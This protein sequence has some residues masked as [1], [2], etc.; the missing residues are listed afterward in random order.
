MNPRK[1]NKNHKRISKKKLKDTQILAICITVISLIIMIS[2]LIH[3]YNVKNYVY[4]KSDKGK[5]LVYTQYLKEDKNYTKEVPYINMNGQQIIEVNNQ[6]KAFSTKYTEL[7][8]AMLTY[9]CQL[10]GDILSVILKAI[11]YETDYASKTEFL[12][13]NINIETQQVLNHLSLLNLFGIDESYVEKKIETQ[14]RKHY[15]EIVKQKYYSANQC[16]FACFLDWRDIDDYLEKN[17]YYVDSG[18][19]YVYKPFV[20]ESIFGEEEY[21]KDEDFIFLIKE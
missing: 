2:F 15:N 11:S 8:R 7:N 19:L 9:E 20:F 5:D 17:A 10:N 4:I 12:S 13:F 1:T 3:N 14:L 21:F 16:N 6:I 18:K